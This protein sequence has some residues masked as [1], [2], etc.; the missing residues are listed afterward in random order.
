MYDVFARLHTF[1]AIDL[2]ATFFCF[3]KNNIN[4][5]PRMHGKANK[6][7]THVISC[8]RKLSTPQDFFRR[9]WADI[10]QENTFNRSSSKLL[11]LPDGTTV[12][13]ANQKAKAVQ[14][15]WRSWMIQ[16]SIV[17]GESIP[18]FFF[19]AIMQL[20][21]WMSH[22]H[23]GLS[24]LA[25]E[26]RSFNA[27]LRSVVINLLLYSEILRWKFY[28]I[29][30]DKHEEIFEMSESRHHDPKHFTLKVNGW[31]MQSLDMLRQR[32]KP[33]S[34]ASVVLKMPVGEVYLVRWDG[35]YI[36]VSERKSWE[37][38]YSALHV[39]V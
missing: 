21:V 36:L 18:K 25:S 17:S 34:S 39:Q 31:C 10:K 9:S 22:N 35:I 19:A 24:F 32:R 11:C 5:L 13:G 28:K 7:S 20:V 14:D 6:Y 26:Y 16:S 33:G 12:A 1:K 38:I 29:S 2:A 15:A 27:L 4:R 8:G 23:M 30:G 37:P 3:K